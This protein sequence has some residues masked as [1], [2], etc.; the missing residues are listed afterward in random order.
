MGGL[1]LFNDDKRPPGHMSRPT[2]VDVSHSCFRYLHRL[3]KADNIIQDWGLVEFKQ[4][5]P[6]GYNSIDESY[7]R[8]S[9]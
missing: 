1:H 4:L 8:S 6:F 3:V 7:R 5:Y 2:Q 9:N